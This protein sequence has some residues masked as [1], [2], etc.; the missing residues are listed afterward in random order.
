MSG[1][2]LDSPSWAIELPGSGTPAERPRVQIGISQDSFMSPSK[3]R[4]MPQGL[5]PPALREDIGPLSAPLPGPTTPRW[6]YTIS[7][8][9]PYDG[10]EDVRR[11]QDAQSTF[12][13]SAS[14]VSTHSRLHVSRRSMLTGCQGHRHTQ[15]NPDLIRIDPASAGAPHM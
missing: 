13:S 12:S 14:L 3:P 10:R 1:Q 8:V 11:Q 9:E 6:Q 7:P 15:S 2:R 5:R 4:A